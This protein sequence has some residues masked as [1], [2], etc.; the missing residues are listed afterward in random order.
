MQAWKE[1]K[2]RRLLLYVLCYLLLF[3]FCNICGIEKV[4]AKGTECC[5]LPFWV[6]VLVYCSS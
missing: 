1:V 6:S 3:V 2:V 4:A 5:R